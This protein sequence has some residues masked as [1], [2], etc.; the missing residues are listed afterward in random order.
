[1]S[2]RQRTASARE[3]ASARTASSASRLPWMSDRIAYRTGRRSGGRAELLV[4]AVEDAVDE[5]ARL[6]GAE[7]LRD[8]DGLVD[9][10][11]GRD[12]ALLEQL[13]HG[14]PQDVAIDDRHPVE[15]PV[16]G[17]LRD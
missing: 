3:A 14:E 6:P 17:V 7:L 1:M 16:L 10:D 8:L 15:I 12:L 2:P 11:L 4:N 9:G 5:T 13:V